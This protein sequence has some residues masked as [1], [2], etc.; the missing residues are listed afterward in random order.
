MGWKMK[1]FNILGFHGKI[2]GLGGSR[3]ANLRG[4]GLQEAGGGGGWGEGGWYPNAH[5]GLKVLKETRNP[6]EI[7]LFNFD[8]LAAFL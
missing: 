3:K 4:V 5:Y 2:Q 7:P 1:K 6:S 8:F